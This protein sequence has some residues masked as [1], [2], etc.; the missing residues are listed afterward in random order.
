MTRWPAGEVGLELIR[1]MVG[2]CIESWGSSVNR[3]VR[4]TRGDRPIS[5]LWSGVVPLPLFNLKT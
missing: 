5:P 2:L 3:R 1:G 4:A